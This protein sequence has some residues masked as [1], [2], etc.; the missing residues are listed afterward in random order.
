MKR[1]PLLLLFILSSF[2]LHA[3]SVPLLWESRYA[4]PGDNSD[5]FN[6]II[7][8]PGGDYVA[9][10]FTTRNGKYKDFL[11]AKISGAN[12]DTMWVR[13]KG[14]GSGDD[15]AISCAVDASG[16]IYVTGYRDGG[17]TQDDIYTIKYDAGGVDLWDTAYNDVDSAFLDDRPVDCGVDPSGNFIIAGWTEQGTW[18]VNQNDYLI[19]KYDSNGN[20]L[21]RTRYDRSGFKDQASA[22][23]IDASGNI[24]VTGRSAVGTDDDWVTMKL[25]GAT[26][27]H[28][29]VPVKIFSS[30]NGDDRAV[31]IAL[32]NAGNPVVAGRATNGLNNDQYRILKYTS[33]G[34]LQWN[35][36]RDA[37]SGNARPT[38]LAIDQTT[39]DVYITGEADQS[40]ASTDYDVYTVK[41]N[42]SGT[43]QWERNWPG[44]ALKE[45][46]G[47]DIV[48]DPFGNVILCGKTD[49][50][51]DP[52]HTNFDWVT[53]KY[54]AN[55][56]IQYSKIKNGTRSD[57][58]EAASL[59]T[60][61]AGNAIVAG[62]INNTTTQKDASRIEYDAIGNPVQEKHYNGE[63][64]FNES[65]HAMVQDANGNT[66]IAGYAYVET[67][68]KNLFAGKID[69]SGNMVDTFLFNGTNDD[70]DELSAIAY[71]GNGNLYACGYT[72]TSGEKSNFILIKF[73]MSLD[74]AWT[75]TYNFINQSDKAVS[76]AV[77]ATGIYVTGMS[78]AD[79]NDTLANE[80]IFTLK[81]DA[82]GNVLWS[83]RYNDVLNLR[84]EP[85]KLILGMG[86][87]IY[88]AG[89]NSNAHDDDIV[90]LSY[91]RTTGNNVTGFPQTWSSNFQ[92]DDR[93]TD[94]IEDASGTIYVAGYS[95]SSSFIEDYTLLKYS[96]AGSLQ[97]SILYDG[98]QE[99]RAAALALDASGNVIVT[100]QT[101]VDNSTSSTNYNYGTLIY[102]AIGNYVC[103]S[104]PFTYNGAGDGDDVPVAVNVNGNEI[105][106]TGQ[107]AEGD[108]IVRN[109]NIM[110][111]FFSEGACMD[112]PE[113]AEYDGPA[114]GDDAP[115]ATILASSS[116][117]ITGSSDGFDNQKDIIT[118]KF[119]VTT[120]MEDQLN[121]DAVSYVYP[122]PLTSTSVISLSNDITGKDLSI[123]IYNVLGE[124]VYSK[125]NIG[126][127]VTL[128]K[129]DFADGIYSYKIFNSGRMVSGGRFVA[130]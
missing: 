50:D 4:G 49:G 125:S 118:V 101:D 67:D 13:T 2:M 9:V 66:Y 94:I 59:V 20:L 24:F 109:K 21:W 86:N 8:V 3:Q 85:V 46:V 73:N 51:P 74:T 124:L 108:T 83:V 129:N 7:A 105:L 28:L 119:D 97:Y 15:E 65:A 54:D 81:Y 107:S 114:A 111:R 128:D 17:T 47:S 87:R 39:N 127:S 93:A 5:K 126:S 80:D 77:D 122:N 121:K 130:D 43:L 30:G 78:D 69:P 106:V 36:F 116:I 98:G 19:L 99:D 100:G 11:T 18:A 76:L 120:G 89:R 57:D 31:D 88:I 104:L 33:A 10:G 45:D 37:I 52:S 1:I 23:A 42:A 92:D 41:Y 95:Q 64:D 112:L 110:V 63:G 61:A 115:N 16:N 79:P 103:P 38:S 32:D 96:P 25:D 82:G 71:D 27:A 102:D 44:A 62:Y 70:D 68:N 12:M 84:D 26:G 113:F 60:D 55:G 56:I 123:G 58:D 48:V 6:K 22:M 90:L 29:W 14:T 72:K 75:R 35:K 91:D 34:G 117:F 40:A 53:I